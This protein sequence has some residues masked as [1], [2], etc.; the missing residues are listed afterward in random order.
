MAEVFGVGI[1]LEFFAEASAVDG[2]MICFVFHIRSI[3]ERP[4][5]NVVNRWIHFE[6][7]VDQPT[8]VTIVMIS[9]LRHHGSLLI[10]R[11]GFQVPEKWNALF[12]N[13]E[14]ELIRET[15]DAWLLACICYSQKVRRILRKSANRYILMLNFSMKFGCLW[16]KPLPFRRLPKYL[17][18]QITCHEYLLQISQ[19]CKQKLEI[20]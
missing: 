13:E 9:M 20:P 3:F 15:L 1:N 5:C 14:N 2:C 16:I 6:Q 18:L 17:H 4:L 7:M 11:E 12:F 19:K 10:A 8:R